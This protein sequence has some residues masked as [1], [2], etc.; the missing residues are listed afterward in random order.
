MAGKHS[1]GT[2]S[3]YRKDTYTCWLICAIV[4]SLMLVTGCAPTAIRPVTQENRNMTN[5][6]DGN[7]QV[8]IREAG[9][10]QYGQGN[11]TYRCGGEAGEFP[12]AVNDSVAQIPY[13]QKLYDTYVDDA[14]KFR[15]E[16]PLDVEARASGTSDSSI[17]QNKMTLIVTGSL[18]EQSGLLVWGVAEFGNDGCKSKLTM[19]RN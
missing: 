8:N 6:Y 10:L 19:V 2:G 15:F 7:W 1:S 3:F 16:I 13:Q 14:G 12:M 9:G 4:G 17:Y 18:K 5:A 11:W